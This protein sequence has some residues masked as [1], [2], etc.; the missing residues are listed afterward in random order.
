MSTNLERCILCF[1]GPNGSGKSTVTSDAP[2]VGEYVNADDLKVK[3]GCSALEAAKIAEGTREY[4][5]KTGTSFTFETVLSTPR[6]LDLLSR[7]KQQGYTVICIFV[8]T[9]HPDINVE[10]VRYRV[11]RGLHDVPEDK[12]RSRYT[13]SLNNIPQLISICDYLYIFDNSIDRSD[14]S[15]DAGRLIA[16][17]IQGEV[18]LFPSSVWSLDALSSL[19]AGTYPQT[20]I[21]E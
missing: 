12:I 4:Y 8:L 10:R 16:R 13:R 17:S 2:I 19:I 1:C 14:N 3:L 11:A 5:L 7:A 20:H 21:I 15:E 18:T 9:K 6:N